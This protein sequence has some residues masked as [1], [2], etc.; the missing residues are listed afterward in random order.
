MTPLIGFQVVAS[1]YFLATGKP[2]KSMILS[3]SRQVIFLIP[4]II[5]IPLYM[6]LT[7]IWVAVAASDGISSILAGFL[8]FTDIKSFKNHDPIRENSESGSLSSS[9]I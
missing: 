8:F 5:V 3:I 7:G 2:V 6:G 1:G 9:A 4:L